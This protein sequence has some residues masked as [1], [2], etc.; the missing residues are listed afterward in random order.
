MS[1]EKKEHPILKIP[2]ES[3]DGRKQ[4]KDYVLPNDL[5]TAELKNTEYFIFERRG[6]PK[7][8]SE[9]EA[10]WYK[11]DGGSDKVDLYNVI[12]KQD[13]HPV[14]PIPCCGKKPMKNK[15]KKGDN[16]N[17]QSGKK[18]LRGIITEILTGDNYN[19]NVNQKV[20]KYHVSKIKKIS[21]QSEKNTDDSIGILVS[22]DVFPLNENKR[23]YLKDK[24][25]DFTN[26]QYNIKYDYSGLCRIGGEI[27]NSFLEILCSII[28]NKTNE[29]KTLE[30]LRRDIIYDINHTLKHYHCLSNII[31]KF[32]SRDLKKNTLKER[33]NTSR[34]NLINYISKSDYIDSKYLSSIIREITRYPDN[35]TFNGELNVNVVVFEDKINKILLKKN[36][37]SFDFNKDDTYILIYERDKHYEKIIIYKNEQNKTT[38]KFIDGLKRPNGEI[39]KYDKIRYNGPKLEKDSIIILPEN[40]IV[41]YIEEI[42]GTKITIRT[43]KDGEDNTIEKDKLIPTSLDNIIIDK[44]IKHSNKKILSG[45]LEF[46]DYE[47]L[48]ELMDKKYTFTRNFIDIT[49]RITHICYKKDKKE[50]CIPIKPSS[51]SKELSVEKYEDNSNIPSVTI[52]F[53]KDILIWIDTNISTKYL[54]YWITE[55]YKITKNYLL[56][57]NLSFLKIEETAGENYENLIHLEDIINDNKEEDK[58]V[59]YMDEYLKEKESEYRNNINLLMYIRKQ[60]KRRNEINM[61][62]KNEIML[63]LDKRLRIFEILKKCK[64]VDRSEIYPFIEL[65]LVNGY[66]KLYYLLINNFTI[67][68][69]TKKTEDE[70]VFKYFEIV[71]KDYKYIFEL[72]KDYNEYIRENSI[73]YD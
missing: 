61:I 64:D 55:E 16:V 66:E 26:I 52:D 3:K 17:I 15:F 34:E 19:V 44:L 48:K 45:E 62:L 47:S 35:R 60:K 21:N 4:W 23:G 11:K 20:K 39:K 65:L 22:K 51:I 27:K 10:Y 41:G 71:N 30:Q 63:D 70:Y 9:K 73:S 43:I 14:Y 8:K 1:A 31:L 58:R 7:G 42:K 46:P 18:I 12:F 6:Q 54:K 53:I 13:V 2:Y 68:Q 67:K 40:N 56:F 38:F 32:M 36:I 28:K 57:N 49:N 5:T 69:V 72:E 37:L 29:F 50:F 24:I 25:V 33:V 59:K